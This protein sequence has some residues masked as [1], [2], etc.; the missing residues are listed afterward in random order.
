M[1]QQLA[2]GALRVGRWRLCGPPAPIGRAPDRPCSEH[3]QLGLVAG[4]AAA[5][6]FGLGLSWLGKSS[7]FRWPVAGSLRHLGGIPVGRHHQEGIV[8]QVVAAC[9]AADSL[10]VGM[11]PEGTGKHAPL[12]KSGLCH[13]ARHAGVPA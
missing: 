13:M 8:G 2:V 4:D 9:A 6:R 1:L 5:A 12:R 7:I 11:T 3:L 10:T